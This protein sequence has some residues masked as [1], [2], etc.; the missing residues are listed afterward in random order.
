MRIAFPN[1]RLETK[2]GITLR[3]PEIHSHPKRSHLPADQRWQPT[4][5]TSCFSTH[6]GVEKIFCGEAIRSSLGLLGCLIFRPK[7]MYIDRF[8]RCFLKNMMTAQKLHGFE[9]RE[10]SDGWGFVSLSCIVQKRKL[11]MND[12]LT[13]S[14]GILPSC[15]PAKCEAPSQTGS[16]AHVLRMYFFMRL[17]LRYGTSKTAH[18]V[19]ESK[20]TPSI[21]TCTYIILQST[22]D[23]LSF[24]Y[25]STIRIN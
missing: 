13:C 11:K 16:S 3:Q 4:S 21:P 17:L 19:D 7:D 12:L 5:V 8:L 22:A 6:R 10:D 9:M 1:L 25:P 2:V 24:N 15:R 23:T 14:G 20:Q 18:E